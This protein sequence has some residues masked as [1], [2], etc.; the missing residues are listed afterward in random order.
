[1]CHSKN[2]RKVFDPKASAK[3]EHSAIVARVLHEF[4][5]CIRRDHRVGK[6]HLAVYLA[7]LERWAW[8]AY[9]HPLRIFARQG[10]ASA[11]VSISAYY[12]CIADLNELGYLSYIP[13]FRNDQASQIYFF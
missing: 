2:Q 6:S 7:L 5:L 3:L 13:S 10:A 8:G 11:R 12:Q 1:M 4:F 9:A